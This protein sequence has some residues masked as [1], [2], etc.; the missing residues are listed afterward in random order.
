[1]NPTILPKSVPFAKLTTFKEEMGDIKKVVNHKIYDT[2]KSEE[3]GRTITHTPCILYK[4]KKD[5]YFLRTGNEIKEVTA[6]I[7]I[8]F[9]EEHNMYEELITY[10]MD[11][12]EEA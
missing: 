7:A 10:F 8:Q 5:N 1:M 9:L 3:I 2:G 12:L 11:R 6:N 4:T